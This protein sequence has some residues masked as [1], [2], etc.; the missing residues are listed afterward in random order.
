ME[1]KFFTDLTTSDRQW[2]LADIG[3][4][5]AMLKEMRKLKWKYG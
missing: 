1:I 4:V 2:F 5:W 3:Y